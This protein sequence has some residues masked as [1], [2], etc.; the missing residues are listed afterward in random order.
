MSRFYPALGSIA[1]VMPLQNPNCSHKW[2]AVNME[3]SRL[4]RTCHLTNM[5]SFYL[6]KNP[7]LAIRIYGNSMGENGIWW[8]TNQ[9]T[10]YLFDP[11]WCIS[12]KLWLSSWGN[13]TSDT[14]GFEGSLFRCQPGLSQ[15]LESQ[16]PVVH[17]YVLYFSGH[18]GVS[19]NLRQIQLPNKILTLELTAGMSLESLNIQENYQGC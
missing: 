7:S 8:Y 16:T 10:L 12:P 18:F 6:D 11:K 4:L 2:R 15:S 9:D 5:F 13:S 3:R 14:S 17:H 19:V 1:K